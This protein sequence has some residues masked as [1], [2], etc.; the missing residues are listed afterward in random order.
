MIVMKYINIYTHFTYYVCIFIDT[1]CCG[2]CVRKTFR[3]PLRLSPPLLLRLL[4]TSLGLLM[5]TA[6]AI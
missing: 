4:F 5:L 1:T 2:K 3:A 6:F